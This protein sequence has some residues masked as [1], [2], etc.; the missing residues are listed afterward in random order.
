VPVSYANSAA[1]VAA[2]AKLVPDMKGG[3]TEADFVTD[4]LARF[5]EDNPAELT[6]DVGDGSTTEYQL[7]ASSFATF[8]L[9]FSEAN[10]ITVERLD[11]S[12]DPYN[13][14]EPWAERVRIDRRT[15]AG[16]PALYLV[17]PTAPAAAGKARVH[18]KAPYTIG[19]STTDL[20]AMFHTAVVR[21]A[22]ALKCSALSTYYKQTIDPAGGSDIFDARQYAQS[23][24]DDAARFEAEYEK[25]VRN[26]GEPAGLSFG[27]AR[28]AIPRVFRPWGG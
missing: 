16:V 27:R 5:S 9:G 25:V 28:S 1:F 11:S 10:P 15:L 18:F 24:A 2:L 21:K 8:V 7:G 13:P 6:V 3:Y 17:F 22:A 26:L 4:A 14:P 23:Y 12:G 20:P 19:A